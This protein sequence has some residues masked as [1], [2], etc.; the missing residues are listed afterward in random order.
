LHSGRD[1]HNGVERRQIRQKPALNVGVRARGDDS[2][3]ELI[4][5]LAKHTVAHL[6][7]ALAVGVDGDNEQ[8]GRLAPEQGTG[9][10][11]DPQFLVNTPVPAESGTIADTHLAALL[12]RDALDQRPQECLMCMILGKQVDGGEITH[13]VSPAG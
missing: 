12:K 2:L 1:T 5:H 13:R 4:P 3:P 6:R 11:V 9:L 8:I 10:L 7:V